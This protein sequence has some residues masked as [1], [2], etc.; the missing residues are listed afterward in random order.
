MRLI[1]RLAG[2]G[3][4]IVHYVAPT[5]WAWRPGRVRHLVGRVDRLLALL[6]F[7]PP[8]LEQAGVRCDYVGHPALELEIGARDPAAFRARHGVPSDARLLCLLPGSRRFEIDRLLPVFG[9]AV[10]RLAAAEPRLAVVLPTLPDLAPLV[11]RG[12][13]HWR[14]PPILLTGE[15]AR[16]DAFAAADLALAAS[17]TVILELARFGVPTVL[18]YRGHPLTMAIVRRLVR[19]RFAGLVNILL[20]REVVPEFI[21]ENCRPEPIA[22][23]L[24]GLLRDPAARER[25]RAGQ[26]EAIDRLG[27]ERQPSERAADILLALLAERG[28]L[29]ARR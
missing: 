13:A 18:A 10:D 1:R 14:R 20:D 23:A 21:Q 4:P 6:P 25:Q 15:A 22:Q 3:V 9:A 16:Y 17:G 5:I 7:E 28:A 29:R 26:R 27:P 12:I 11:E 19:V 8:L 24:L 2:R